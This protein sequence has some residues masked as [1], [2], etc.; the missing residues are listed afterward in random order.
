LFDQST[1]AELL[2]LEGDAG[3][4]SLFSRHPVEWLTWADDRLI[5]DVDTPQDLDRARRV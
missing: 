1:F 5:F 2:Q 4:R 3:G